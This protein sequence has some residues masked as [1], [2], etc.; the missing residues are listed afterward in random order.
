MAYSDINPYGYAMAFT[1]W[2]YCFMVASCD[3][4]AQSYYKLAVTNL[5]YWIS[6]ISCIIKYNHLDLEL[7]SIKIS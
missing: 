3:Q 4:F 1:N 2:F 5:I 7:I 6:D